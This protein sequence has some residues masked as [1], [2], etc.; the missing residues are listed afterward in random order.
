MT[1]SILL[2]IFL[3]IV[4]LKQR[5]LNIIKW[6]LSKNILIRWAIYFIGIFAIIIFGYYGSTDGSEFIYFQF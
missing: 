4:Q 5:H 1:I 6:V 2:L 3:L